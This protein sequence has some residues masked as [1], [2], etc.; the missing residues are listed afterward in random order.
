[1]K[2]YIEFESDLGQDKAIHWIDFIKK[3]CQAT[4]E[5]ENFPYDA[6]LS[7]TFT[8]NNEIRMLNREYRGKDKVTDVLSFPLTEYDEN[9]VGEYCFNPD[10]NAA[11]LG[12]IVISLEKAEQQ[13]NEYEHSLNREIGFL[14]V[15][16]VLHLLGYDH[17]TSDEDEIYMNEKQ[18][19]V[20]H[21]LGI[22]RD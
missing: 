18:E 3:C 4:L 2:V 11:L 1:M 6:E 10:R 7:V 17:E 19:A 8:D 20:L 9:R 5:Q 16:S 12:D 15:H 13:A 14:I 22:T 21:S